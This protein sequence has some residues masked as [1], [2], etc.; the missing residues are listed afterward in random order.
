MFPGWGNFSRECA[1]YEEWLQRSPGRHVHPGSQLQGTWGPGR[2]AQ[3]R[4]P[5][6]QLRDMASRAKPVREAMGMWSPVH[7]RWFS[8]SEP[9][10]RCGCCGKQYG[11]SS[12]TSAQNYHSNPPSRHI[13]QRM[14][15]KDLQRYLHA[16]VCC[17]LIHNSRNCKQPKWPSTDKWIN[18]MQDMHTMGSY[19]VTKR[20]AVLTQVTTG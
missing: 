7:A 3:S 14:E 13:L 17:S 18:K 15:S 12:N 2:P 6:R 5:S 10:N 4:E 11:A 1:L 20:N 19:S 16:H 8:Q 9:L